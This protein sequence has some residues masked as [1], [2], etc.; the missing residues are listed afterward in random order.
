MAR[1]IQ[2]N[3]RTLLVLVAFAAFVVQMAMWA[4]FVYREL[5]VQLAQAALVFCVF[6]LLWFVPF[7]PAIAKR[8]R[9]R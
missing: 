9:R 5:V 6:G 8:R 7:L 4:W 3:L 2:F 1:R